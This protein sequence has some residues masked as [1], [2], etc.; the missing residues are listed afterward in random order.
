MKPQPPERFSA[1]TRG[2]GEMGRRLREHDWSST[3][4]EVSHWPMAL[5]HAVALCLRTT[6]PMAVLWG[7]ERI[8]IYNDA[9]RLG[10]V[11]YSRRFG[12]GWRPVEDDLRCAIDRALTG[13]TAIL[14]DG[15]TLSP[16]VDELGAIVGLLHLF[17][18]W[19]DDPDPQPDENAAIGRQ[20]LSA[21]FDT[22]S[23]GLAEITLEGRFARVNEELCRI[24][25]LTREDLL[26]LTI[27]DLTYPEDLWLT[28]RALEE[29]LSTGR[30]TGFD[31]RYQP[32]NTP[33]IWVN[34]SAARLFDA[35]GR[36]GNIL[37]VTADLS[38]RKLAEQAL[39]DSEAKLRR[40]AEGI[41]QL[42]WRA[43]GQGRWTWAGPQ[44]SRFTGQSEAQSLN[45][46]W[47]EVVHPDDRA[48]AMAAWSEA[49]ANGV[50]EAE[51]RIRRADDGA[52]IWHHTRSLPIGEDG[53]VEW[54]GTS[55]DM[56]EVKEM[57][58]RQSLLVNELQHRTRN[59]IGV[60][61]SMADRTLSASGS[62]E[63]FEPVF[64]DRLA[65]LARVQ[66]LLSRLSDG[67]RVTLDALIRSELGAIGAFDGAPDRIILNG[68]P[69]ARLRSRTL[70]TF[71]M[72]LHELATNAAKYGALSHDS[73]RLILSWREQVDPV[74][75][76]TWLYVDWRETGMRGLMPAQATV[77][78]GQGRELIER[79]LPY[80]LGART[81]FDITPDGVHCTIAMPAVRA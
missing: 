33:P 30:A 45:L 43:Q 81:T 22:A 48:P 16:I 54:L 46:G 67:E 50:F 56:Q 8:Q 19:P 12:E 38:A 11:G 68:S 58:Q 47:L 10:A 49:R 71:S 4:G 55:T 13:T 32:P 2:G 26:G 59:L 15:S 65:L 79:A 40:L 3:L 25:G 69:D 34:T 6:L 27:Q 60:V 37:V 61:R 75:N 44:W 72:A 24:M 1:F 80:Q 21:I 53:E 78:G 31:K 52:W 77:G 17:A 70:Q 5:R 62:L 9:Y 63:E 76:E 39:A 28:A 29:V 35:D 66:G 64:R 42:V 73:G 23:V 74:D 18:D 14:G 41:P 57:Q 36:P 20:R 7:P 51:F